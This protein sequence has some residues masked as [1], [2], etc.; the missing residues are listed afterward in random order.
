MGSWGYSELYSFPFVIIL[1]EAYHREL[2]GY[3]SLP[4]ANWRVNILLK[5]NGSYR[6]AHNVPLDLIEERY[7]EWARD[8]ALYGREPE[9]IFW[10]IARGSA[11]YGGINVFLVLGREPY[12]FSAELIRTNAFTFY[13]RPYRNTGNI[14]RGALADWALLAFGLREGLW[15]IVLMACR[16]LGEGTGD[17]CMLRTS[18]GDLAIAGPT[19]ELPGFMR[20]FPDNSPMRH[21]IKYGGRDIR[22]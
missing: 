1:G 17:A 2:R 9:D 8:F 19:S 18:S 6:I 12:L 5:S 10:K 3:V 7:I 4:L 14:S 20:V 11:Y 16:A 13:L 15:D 22:G 21:V